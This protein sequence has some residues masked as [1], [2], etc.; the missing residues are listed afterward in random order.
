MS[1]M[2]ILREAIVDKSWI[3]VD[4]ENLS[5]LDSILQHSSFHAPGDDLELVELQSEDASRVLD[6]SPH[7]EGARRRPRVQCRR[8]VPHL[9]QNIMLL[10]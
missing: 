9:K 7:A 8:K 6:E 10:V 1:N 5:S 4:L 3:H 2:Q